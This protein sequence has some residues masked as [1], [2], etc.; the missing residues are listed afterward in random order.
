M[1]IATVRKNFLQV[2]LSGKRVLYAYAKGEI[3]HNYRMATKEEVETAERAD[4]A[5]AKELKNHYALW[6][7]ENGRQIAFGVS[8]ITK[9]LNNLD[10]HFSGFIARA[11]Y[12]RHTPSRMDLSVRRR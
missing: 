12:V 2:H 10:E 7:K 6:V 4:P 11:A 3:P 1:A 8:G 5:F 9:G